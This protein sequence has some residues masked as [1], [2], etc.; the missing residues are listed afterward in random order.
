LLGDD[1]LQHELHHSVIYSYF[2]EII[3]TFKL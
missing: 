1:Q 2:P 3:N